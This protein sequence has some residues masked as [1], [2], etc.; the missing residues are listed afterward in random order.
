MFPS[1]PSPRIV[2]PLTLAAALTAAVS[3][4]AA[5]VLFALGDSVTFGEDDLV[6]EP[7]PGDRGY[8]SRLADL[9][10]LGPGPRPP[11]AQ[12][13]HR[14]RDGRELPDG[15][16]PPAA[17]GGPHRPHPGAAEHVLRR[18]RRDRDAAG[19]V[20]GRPSRPSARWATRSRPSPSRWASTSS[21]RSPPCPPTRRWPPSPRRSTPTRRATRT[22]SPPSA[23]SLP[24]RRSTCRPTTTRSRPTPTATQRRSSSRRAPT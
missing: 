13:R 12:L 6:Y 7:V 8:V 21:P 24:T 3:A 23:A 1:H 15:R 2:A 20:P 14:R 19:E 4:H 9:L 22:C 16:G 17:R 5:P 18:G 11:R 10:A